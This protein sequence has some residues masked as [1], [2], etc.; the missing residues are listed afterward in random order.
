MHSDRAM[1]AEFFFF[2]RKYIFSSFGLN[3]V[4]SEQDTIVIF[5]QCSSLL[6]SACLQIIINAL[7]CTANVMVITPL[8]GMS[9]TLFKRAPLCILGAE[10]DYSLGRCTFSSVL[11]YRIIIIVHTSI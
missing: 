3:F 6:I 9:F 5:V 2:P 1:F 7:A 11:P 4:L 10:I 8:V